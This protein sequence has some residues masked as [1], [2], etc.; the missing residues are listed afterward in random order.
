M[1]RT[2]P[3]KWQRQRVS[4]ESRVRNN[5][6]GGGGRLAAGVEKEVLRDVERSAGGE[7]ARRV[8][9]VAT[10]AGRGVPK[11]TSAAAAAAQE[12]RLARLTK[13]SEK[14]LK[15]VT[16]D[17]KLWARHLAR[18]AAR[19]LL[20]P[21]GLA[22]GVVGATVKAMKASGAYDKPMK[23]MQSKSKSGGPGKSRRTGERA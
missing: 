15:G 4:I 7:A 16:G 13:G 21:A 8:R 18:S 2:G 14:V 1:A 10:M 22:E 9:S 5:P 3:T 12:S 23:V 20:S 19:G 6:Q 11:G 17:G